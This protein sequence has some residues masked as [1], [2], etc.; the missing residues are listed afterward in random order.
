MST[1]LSTLTGAYAVDA[2]A[3]PERAE[4]EHHLAVCDEC[5]REV[6]ELRETAARLGA[7]I[8]VPAPDGLKRRVLHE[9]TQTRQA[10]PITEP[11]PIGSRQARR[12]S[13]LATRL[14]VA[15]AVVGIAAAGVLGGITWQSHQELGQVE[16]QLAQAGARNGEMAAVLHASDARIVHASEGGAVATAVVSEQA[17]EAV[18]LG[19]RMPAAGENRVHQLWAIGPDGASSMGVMEQAATPI[20]HRLPGDA[21]KLGVTTEPEGGSPQ[22]TTDPFLLLSLRA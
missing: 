9:V 19:E 16:Q 11:T 1:E 6:R 8:A 22:P 21:T 4:F 10:P 20:V 2:L 7:G 14:A 18:F 5:A 15:A 17:G 3:G 13:T 12:R